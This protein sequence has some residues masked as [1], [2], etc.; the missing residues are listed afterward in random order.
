MHIEVAAYSHSDSISAFITI[1]KDELLYTRDNEDT[2]FTS[3]IQIEIEQETWI[4]LDTLMEDSKRWI[5]GRFDVV[6]SSEDSEDLGIIVRVADLNRQTTVEEYLD[7]SKV[8]VMNIEDGWPISGSSVAVGTPILLISEELSSWDVSHVVP[9]ANLPA[10]PFSGYRNPLDTLTLKHHS[11]IDDRWIVLDGCQKFNSQELDLTLLIHGRTKSFPIAKDI[12]HL[13]ETTRYIATRSEFSAMKN[14]RHKKEALDE[15]WLK[16][17]KSPERAKDLIKIY[18]SRVEEANRAFSGIQ[19][20]CRTDRGMVHIIHG[21]PQRVRRDYWNE[22]WIY[23][24]EG[25]NNTLTFRFRRRRHELD[26]NRFR[27]ER[28]IIYRST[29]DRMVTSWRNGRVHQD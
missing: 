17:G 15:F 28:N 9:T 5:R 7:V 8:L 10:P 11:T 13:I 12:T 23:G 24:E 20:G 16:C 19:E 26:N 2:P 25:T 6:S 4:I 22:Y 1:D 3:T 14:A 18:Y 27:L 21:V 29:W